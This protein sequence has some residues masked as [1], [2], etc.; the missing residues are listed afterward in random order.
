M[1]FF[2]IIPER[3][4]IGKLKEAV[5]FSQEISFEQGIRGLIQ[6]FQQE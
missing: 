3:P 5:G 6:E 1:D 2:N 4:G